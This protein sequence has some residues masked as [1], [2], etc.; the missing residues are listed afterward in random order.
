M[1]RP[2]TYADMEFCPYGSL[3][4]LIAPGRDGSEVC[5]SHLNIPEEALWHIFQ[6]LV[7]ACLVLQ[8]GA[9]EREDAVDDWRPIV[10]RDIKPDNVWLDEPAEEFPSYPRAR[11]GDFGIAIMTDEN[12]PYNPLA[13][14]DGMRAKFWRAPEQ[15]LYLSPETLTPLKGDKLGEKTNVWQLGAVMVRLMSRTS[16]PENQTPGRGDYRDPRTRK[17]R[18]GALGKIEYSDDLINLVQDCTQPDP[19][20]RPSLRQLR[21]DIF[22]Y[23]GSSDAGDHTDDLRS[24]KLKRKEKPRLQ[25]RYPQ[26]EE[27]YKLYMANANEDGDSGEESSDDEEEEE[28]GR[29]HRSEDGSGENDSEEE[30]GDDENGGDADEDD[31]DNE[32][33]DDEI[34]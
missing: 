29:A 13:Y 24:R 32:G 14:N 30:S 9:V 8:Y 25:L 7:D 16:D 4:D 18:V 3:Q 1:C 12:D 34:D 19:Q 10:H 28:S 22:W 33:T 21:D 23:T 11:L 20:E 26:E 17:L 31:I 27:R 15:H 5:H 6:N 2:L